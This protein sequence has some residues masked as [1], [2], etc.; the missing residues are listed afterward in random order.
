M[1]KIQNEDST[2]GSV[3]S[4][5]TLFFFASRFVFQWLACKGWLLSTLTIF[6][7]LQPIS[8]CLKMFQIVGAV[9]PGV[10]APV[11]KNAF[12]WHG[13]FY[14]GF[15]GLFAGELLLRRMKMK[16]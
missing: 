4:S 12:G 3:L 6:H 1:V 7:G 14:V 2:A 9:I 10:I 11:V 8:S 16:K 5:S 15:G 13:I